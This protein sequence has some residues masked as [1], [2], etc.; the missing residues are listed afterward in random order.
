MFISINTLFPEICC[1]RLVA[2]MPDPKLIVVKYALSDIQRSA[3][4]TTLSPIC[5][6]LSFVPFND[7]WPREMIDASVVYSLPGFPSG[8]LIR[9]PSEDIRIPSLTTYDTFAPPISNDSIGEPSKAV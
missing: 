6:V 5:I 9:V 1:A 8:Y 2:A 3:C 4:A 7:H